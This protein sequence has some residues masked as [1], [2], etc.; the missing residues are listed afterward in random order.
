MLC[1]LYLA[2]FPSRQKLRGHCPSAPI[3]VQAP[4]RRDLLGVP[5]RRTRCRLPRRDRRARREPAPRQRCGDAPAQSLQA[6]AQRHA[7]RSH[8]E[9]AHRADMRRFQEIVEESFATGRM[10]HAAARGRG[11]MRRWRRRK[12]RRRGESGVGFGPPRA[13]RGSQQGS[14]QEA[15][16]SRRWRRPEIEKMRRARHVGRH[17]SIGWI[18]LG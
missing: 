15:G 14:K 5:P 4:R 11:S 8:R 12:R 10:W 6:G 9:A 7:A 18:R 3:A 13:G 2:I 16:G 1:M 17:S